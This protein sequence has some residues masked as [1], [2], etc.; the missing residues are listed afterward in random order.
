[1]T[2]SKSDLVEYLQRDD[3]L[4]SWLHVGAVSHPDFPLSYYVERVMELASE[5]WQHN[6]RAKYD[7][8]LRVES[9]NHILFEKHR[10]R[11]KG[12]PYKNIVDDPSRFMLHELL[13][14]KKGNPLVIA[15]LYQIIAQQVGLNSHCIALPNKYWICVEDFASNFY[16]DPFDFGRVYTEDEFR[17]K[18]RTSMTRNRLAA[19]SLFEKTDCRNLIARVMQHLKQVFIMRSR[20]LEALRIVELLTA[21]YPES[22]ELTRD[23]GI[24]YCEIEYFS[25]ALEDLSIYLKTCPK[26][27]DNR[28]IRR[29]AHM[30]RD[31]QEVIN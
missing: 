12:E 25:K 20:A 10:F 4:R 23:R 24:L 11:R 18:L 5:V 3:L 29:L 17:K 22:P 26:A 7:P 14:T 13:E 27:D 31:Q 6:L 28:E 16:V 2:S 19:T 8:M 1:M 30:L 21:I 9:I 15:M